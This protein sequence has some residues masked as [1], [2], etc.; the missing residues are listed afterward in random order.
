MGNSI[1]TQDRNAC[2]VNKIVESTNILLLLNGSRVLGPELFY[3]RE[4]QTVQRGTILK[5]KLNDFVTVCIPM[6]RL[7]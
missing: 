1:E 4:C 5:F 2:V 3:G 6:V 7:F